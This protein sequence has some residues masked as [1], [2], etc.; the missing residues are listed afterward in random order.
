MSPLVRRYLKT[1]IGFLLAGLGLGGVL[2]GRRELQGVG[3]SPDLVSA[4]AHLILVGFVMMMILGV[5]LWMFPRPERDD[6]RYHPA[7]AEVSYWLV[8][9]GTAVRAAGETLRATARP[10]GFGWAVTVAGW[11]QIA[12]LALFFYHLWP[13]IRSPRP[14][15]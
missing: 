5:A 6:P 3:P 9:F 1:G 14:I 11:A 8:T 7:L 2:L 15:K 13:R 10:P 12:G 4:H